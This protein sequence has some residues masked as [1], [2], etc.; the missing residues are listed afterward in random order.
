MHG[1]GVIK[2][3][4]GSF[5]YG[6]WKDSMMHGKGILMEESM[7]VNGKRIRSMEKEFLSMLME[8]IKMIAFPRTKFNILL[9]L[10]VTDP[11]SI[12][13]RERTLEVSL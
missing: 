11:S 3:T 12:I 10:L 7:M 2:Y 4:D 8:I 9:N 6:E 1:T 13:T 5:Y